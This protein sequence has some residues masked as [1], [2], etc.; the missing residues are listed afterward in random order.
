MLHEREYARGLPLPQ[1]HL[2]AATGNLNALISDAYAHFEKGHTGKGLSL[3][4]RAQ[5]IQVQATNPAAAKRVA[6]EAR[7][8][9]VTAKKVTAALR[10]IRTIRAKYPEEKRSAVG[11]LSPE[12]RDCLKLFR[13]HRNVAAYLPT[14]FR[15]FGVWLQH[16]PPAYAHAKEAEL[17]KFNNKALKD[18]EKKNKENKKNRRGIF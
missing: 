12:K 6:K 9:L 17:L 2:K 10:T 11:V 5:A 7:E 16:C 14:L 8:E 3:I 4:R 18:F 13:S 1:I 15:H